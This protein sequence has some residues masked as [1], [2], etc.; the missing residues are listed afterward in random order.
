M[1]PS[2]FNEEQA[3]AIDTRDCS[4]LVSAP[5]GSGKTKILV[6]RILSLLKDDFYNIDQLLVLT[7]T[8]PAAYE[9]KQRLQ[10]DLL[11]EIKNSTDPKVK[12]HLLKQKDHLDAAYITN[13]HGFCNLL[14]QQYGYLLE[15]SSDFTIC[16]DNAG[17]KNKI[18]DQCLDQWVK[19]STFK[20]FIQT[21]YT[22]Y[23]FTKFRENFLALDTLYTTTYEFVEYMEEMK[24]NFYNPMIQ[25][26]EFSNWKNYPILKDIVAYKL[27]LAYNKIIELHQFCLENGLSDFTVNPKADTEKKVLP[28]PYQSLLDWHI[29]CKKLLETEGV[30]ALLK[31][32]LKPINASKM[33]WNEDTSPY[34]SNY[35]TKKGA[36]RTDFYKSLQ[37]YVFENPLAFSETLEVSLQAIDYFSSLV[38]E[39]EK[40]FSTYKQEEN[41]LDFND[42]EK[43]ALKLLDKSYGVSDELYHK[44][45][46][47]MIDEYQDTNQ[48]QETLLSKI[49]NYQNP[50]IPC[51]MV[52]DM[53]QSI[54][55][56]RQAD[57]RI[58]KEKYDRY[59]DDD[60]TTKRIDLL[61]NY[62]SNK[63]VLDSINYI[64]NQI[65]DTRIGGLEYLKDDSAKLNYD[66]LRK[67]KATD[68][69]ELEALTNCVN[70]RYK[71]EDR[72]HTEVLLTCKTSSNEVQKEEY[73]A[74]LVAKRIK[75]L[76]ENMYLDDQDG[77]KYVT[78]YKDIVVL[79]RST[80]QF[81]TFKKVFDRYGIPNNMIL[82]QGFLTAPEVIDC[83]YA[84]QAIN[85]PYDDIAFTSLLTGNYLF[86]GF[87][88]DWIVKIKDVEAS[89]MYQKVVKYQE[90]EPD[91]KV[92]DF[93]AY[94]SELQ[95]YSKAHS[96]Y[97]TLSKFLKDSH[98]MLFVSALINGVQ[99]VANLELLLEKTDNY[100]NGTLYMMVQDFLKQ[101][102][103]EVKLSPGVLLS[104]KNDAV[105]F[106]TIHKSKGLEY[107]I[108]FV[109]QMHKE[110][111][112]LDLQAS[113]LFD[114]N[115]GMTTKPRLSHEL[116]FQGKIVY[117]FENTYHKILSTLIR[118]EIV[119]EE[120]RI[121]Y[122]ALTRASQKI[123][124][125]GCI[126]EPQD[127]ITYINRAVNNNDDVIHHDD[128]NILLYDNCRDQKTYLDWMMASIARHPNF[129]EQCIQENLVHL[130]DTI[131]ETLHQKALALKTYPTDNDVFTNTAHAKFF[132]DYI[133]DY[134]LDEYKPTSNIKTNID[135]PH[136]HRI[137]AFQYPHPTSLQ[138]TIGVTSKIED[139][140][141]EYH[142]YDKKAELLLSASETGT[143]VHHV[144]E[145]L[146][147]K[148]EMNLG[149]QLNDICDIY[150]NEKQRT[151]IEKYQNNIQ[152][153]F[154]SD[155]YQEILLSDVIYKEKHFTL[156]DD[157]KQIIHGIFDLICI[158]DQ[159]IHII[160]YK[161]DRLK[162]D[163]NDDILMNA[164]LPQMNY[165]RKMMEKAYPSYTIKTTVYYL[166]I[167]R[168]VS[169]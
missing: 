113:L 102:E 6:R 22:E 24:A 87:K 169:N 149:K 129:I 54:Y 64:F 81:V 151:V 48:I 98:Y 15:L 9:M 117:E 118:N 2:E 14:L 56:F 155:L 133:P 112:F 115:A 1:K 63:V 167:N 97:E 110:F 141:R 139:G 65:M 51:F 66:Y 124:C 130:N 108:V 132:V 85:Q 23:R 100:K 120:M 109:S 154:E 96:C 45:K 26:D 114:R 138:K 18:L 75:E 27:S 67:E 21:Y 144:F 7:F 38:V 36:I 20:E 126:K 33:S 111:N 142:S 136:Y 42:L 106:T 16:S 52:G 11:V 10:N 46:E 72:F 105:T 104:T 80:T 103:Q 90:L 78:R 5:A 148:Q 44:L 101:I 161:T 122:V 107:P 146:E 128:Q 166:H 99:R 163:T 135:Y 157:D 94:H 55:R 84:L 34:K 143:L 49:A 3:Q 70:A 19:D 61:F 35:T 147:F 58:F 131:L 158:K 25:K 134:I 8:K 76:T 37:S 47:I 59:I 41:V 40:A 79:M 140:N 13:F 43:Y 73:E 150:Y 93:L 4:I 82:S 17:I 28:T 91:K 127:F 125:T 68:T 86:S 30:E 145:V 32:N 159:T 53:K 153:F 168:Y 119:N 156:L 137:K 92:A 74:I 62:R 160:D 57:P 31:A 77:Q 95:S 71:K 12:T 89:S 83:I 60:P 164:H 88:E 116:L 121:L 50:S 165:Y 29:A 162:E 69:S 123:I 152:K 39:F